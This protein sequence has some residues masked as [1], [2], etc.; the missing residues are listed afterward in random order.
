MLLQMIL[1]CSFLWGGNIPLCTCT[2]FS[3]CLPGGGS[4]KELGC[5][6]RRNK[7][8]GFDPWVGKIPWRRAW[9]PILVFLPGESYGWRSLVGYVHRVTKSQTRLKWFS[10]HEQHLYP[11][12]CQWTFRLFPC[13][14]YC[15][16]CCYE[17][18]GACIFS[19]YGFLQVYA[20]EWLIW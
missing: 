2:T 19:N 6:W 15:E 8:H 5:Q 17:H 12:I 1:F 20:Q 7:R 10:I 16:Y 4:G 14:G 11:F 13:F 18:R 3:L 9:H